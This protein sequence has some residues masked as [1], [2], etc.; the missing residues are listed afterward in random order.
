MAKA[1]PNFSAVRIWRPQ[2]S[3]HGNMAKMKSRDVEYAANHSRQHVYKK[4]CD[5]SVIT[6]IPPAKTP[7]VIWT[8]GSQ[9]VPSRVMYQSF[10]TGEHCTNC[11]MPHSTILSRVS[12]S[13]YMGAGWWYCARDVDGDD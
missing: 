10:W 7:I 12:M 8:R 3:N 2:M 9:H 4:S 11:M 1:T 5:L 13:C 6:H